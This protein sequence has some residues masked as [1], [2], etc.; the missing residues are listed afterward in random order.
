M[1]NKNNPFRYNNIDIII[2]NRKNKNIKGRVKTR[3]D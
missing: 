3:S 1:L 2:K